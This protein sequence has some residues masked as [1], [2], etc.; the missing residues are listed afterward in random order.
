M[1]MRPDDFTKL[2]AAIEPLDTAKRR[3]DYLMGWF[4]NADRCK[5][6]EMRYR[7]DL[8]WDSKAF[9]GLPSDLEDEH[10]HTALKKIIP[11]LRP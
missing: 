1:K 11:L 9:S 5:D 4:P 3:A 6:V 10:I 7:W 8:L 2:K